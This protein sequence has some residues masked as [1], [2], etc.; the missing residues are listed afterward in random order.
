[1]SKVIETALCCQ[2]IKVPKELCQWAPFYAP[3]TFKPFE[4]GEFFV[5]LMESSREKHC[6]GLV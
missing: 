1:M 2:Q 4:G 6:L 3:Y 5:V